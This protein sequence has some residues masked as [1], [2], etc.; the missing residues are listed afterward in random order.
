MFSVHYSMAFLVA[1]YAGDY[2]E[3]FPL[4]LWNI[5]IQ[6]CEQGKSLITLIL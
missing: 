3:G 5:V 4:G 2:Q 6:Q 1:V